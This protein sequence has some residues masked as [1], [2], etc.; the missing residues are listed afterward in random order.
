MN[1]S[2]PQMLLEVR[3]KVLMLLGNGYSAKQK[4][5][6]QSRLLKNE[7]NIYAV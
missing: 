7:L 6:T 2:S 1:S 4:A 5:Q 3:G